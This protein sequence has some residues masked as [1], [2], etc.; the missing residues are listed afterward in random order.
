MGAH[1]ERVSCSPFDSLPGR[2]CFPPGDE[3]A[4]KNNAWTWVWQR[5]S[6]EGY[7]K[8]RTNK[9]DRGRIIQSLVGLD[10]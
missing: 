4:S 5:D 10:F 6:G 2:F 1:A 3:I 7:T 9:A 8:E